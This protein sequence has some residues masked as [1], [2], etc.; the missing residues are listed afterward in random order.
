[1]SL[2][3]AGWG[4]TDGSSTWQTEAEGRRVWGQPE[5]DSKDPVPKT[6]TKK[7]ILK[8]SNYELTYSVN[9]WVKPMFHEKNAVLS[10]MKTVPQSAGILAASGNSSL[11]STGDL[12][13]G[14]TSQWCLARCHER[15]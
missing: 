12:C 15:D 6:E 9:I 8:T 14:L 1:M 5:L 10:F 13:D 4:H 7:N 3:Q 2:K 11:L